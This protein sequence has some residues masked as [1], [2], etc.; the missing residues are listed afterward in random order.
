[1]F[2]SNKTMRNYLPILIL[3][4]ILSSCQLSPAQSNVNRIF[5]PCP[6]STTKAVVEV[7]SDGDI[8]L[9]TCSGREVQINTGSNPSLGRVNVAYNDRVAI[10]S[11]K[12]DLSDIDI[13]ALNSVITAGGT[14][15]DRTIN[16]PSGTVNFAAGA[17][18]AGI[19][20]TSSIVTANSL[21][22]ATART[23]DATCSVKNVVPGVG[24][25]VIRM[26]ANCTAE[27]SVNFLIFNQ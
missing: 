14:T 15:G 23:N 5:R 6:S 16:E 25:F 12:L 1:M 2:T 4:F 26:T 17:G 24:S 19:T 18:T 3:L 9:A 27:T 22:F 11:P 20:V 8:N 7:Q 21:V 10:S 13:Y